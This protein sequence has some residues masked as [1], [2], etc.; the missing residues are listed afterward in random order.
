VRKVIFTLHPLEGLDGLLGYI[1]K[2][3]SSEDF[4]LAIDSVASEIIPTA[5]GNRPDRQQCL[6]PPREFLL[7]SAAAQ[8][9]AAYFVDQ[10]LRIAL[11][12]PQSNAAGIPTSPRSST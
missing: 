10:C 2:A 1:A 8:E 11:Q 7:P 12:A 9:T 4:H 6:A 5:Q 3:D